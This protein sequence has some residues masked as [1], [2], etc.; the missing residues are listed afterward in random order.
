MTFWRLALG[1]YPVLDGEG[2]RR[3]GGRW[4]DP[5]TPLVY[6]SEHPALCLVETLVHLDKHQIP[7]EYVLYRMEGPTPPLLPEEVLPEDWR[8][9]VEHSRSAVRAWAGEARNL[10]L[11]V[12]SAVVPHA[13]NILLNPLHPDAS[14][15]EVTQKTPFQFDK[16]LF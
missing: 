13:R 12:P 2:A 5:G 14:T 9:D 10:L 16:R 11:S 1:S 6:L 8:S 3:Y 15:V 7:S 4:N